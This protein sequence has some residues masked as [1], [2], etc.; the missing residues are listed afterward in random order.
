MDKLEEKLEQEYEEASD[1]IID[2]KL[3]YEMI[4]AEAV[5][6]GRVESRMAGAERV[7][8][9]IKFWESYGLVS[10]ELSDNGPYHVGSMVLE[11]LLEAIVNGDFLSLSTEPEPVC[12]L[13]NM[14]LD[15]QVD[16]ISK[17]MPDEEIWDT[18]TLHDALVDKFDD[19]QMYHVDALVNIMKGRGLIDC[20]DALSDDEFYLVSSADEKTDEPTVDEAQE[21]LESLIGK[22]ARLM[23]MSGEE[24]EW[25]VED[26]V[27]GL[28]NIIDVS[29]EAVESTVEIMI[30]RSLVVP[31]L[32]NAF[33]LADGTPENDSELGE[34][35]LEEEFIDQ[36]QE[37]IETD[38]KRGWTP[39][40]IAGLLGRAGV[41]DS[42]ED[43]TII[44]RIKDAL[45]VLVDSNR[46]SY[47]PPGEPW[48]AEDRWRAIS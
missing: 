3:D 5:V 13:G 28:K 36:V 35:M 26:I 18:V 37:V 44:K 40:D 16:Y 46:I 19:V 27:F 34:K 23:A 10:G 29:Q 15:E 48:P 6:L 43:E 25:T 41:F 30:N 38:G 47:I 9:A 39:L 32:N 24:D 4:V 2:R 11:A 1:K 31:R 42:S 20:V 45:S 21:D 12:L 8:E 22:I 33:A 17:L 7:R 14:T